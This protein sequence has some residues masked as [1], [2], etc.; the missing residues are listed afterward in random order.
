M[1]QHIT[2]IPRNQLVFISLEDTILPENP[3][4]FI[5][6]FVEALSLHTLGFSVQTLKTEGR[7]SFDTKVFLKIYLYGYLNGLRSSRKLEKECTRNIELQWLLCGIVPNY[8]SIS[9]FR[10]QNPAGLKNLFKLF[11]SFLKDA[12]M[13]GGE[14]IAIDG[15]KIRA[16]NSKKANFNQ[17]KI[18]RHLAY[19]E[20]RTQE[21]LTQL[22]QNDLEDSSI[23]VTKIQ[24]KIERLKKNKLHYEILA[25]KLKASEQPQIS[26]TDQ[27][28]RALLV[29]GV[30]VEISYNMQAAVDNKHNLVVA[31][32]T[33]NRND[34]NA[35]SAI[36]LEAKEN[37]GVDTFTALVDKGYHNGR[38]IA[39]CIKHNIITIVAHPTPGKSKESVT[40]LDYLVAKFT[41][42]KADD[43]YT[44]PQGA[45]L[46]TT[47]RW[48]KKSGRTEQSGYQF[49]KYRTPSCKECPVKHLCTS[50]T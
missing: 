31:T 25:A 3:V 32:H 40:Q 13:I 50:R 46:K 17:K 47:G 9:D 41:Y 6:A 20:E 43:T 29:Q 5:D 12:D 15:T 2:G 22:E 48:H 28:A 18:D 49:K 8:H 1:M 35:L 39:Q 44:C 16:H 14:T 37:L 33:I 27:D 19:I 24:E 34:L 7:P 38:E 21:Y 42:N 30:V 11:V 10:K 45:T 23:T 36:A 4:R 26:T